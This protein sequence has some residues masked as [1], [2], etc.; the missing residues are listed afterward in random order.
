VSYRALRRLHARNPRFK[1]E[2]WLETET[3]L[4]RERVLS[5]S[6]TA[7]GGSS[8][9]RN[10]VLRK[11]LAGEAETLAAG[12]ARGALNDANYAF[13]ADTGLQVKLIPKRVDTLLVSGAALFSEDAD[14]LE[15]SGRLTKNPSFW[16]RNVHVRRR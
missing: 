9:I 5:W 11:A 6:V 1:A 14:L 15:V 2:G 7:E 12:T 16:M 4:T 3:T 10:R 13:V 8:Y